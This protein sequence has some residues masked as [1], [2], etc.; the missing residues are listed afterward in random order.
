MTLGACVEI[1]GV[2]RLQAPSPGRCE[3]GGSVM[4]AYDLA[5]LRDCCIWAFSQR[6]SRKGI[7]GLA[8]IVADGFD[9]DPFVEPLTFFA[10]ATALLVGAST[11][12]KTPYY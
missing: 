12:S 3:V 1:Q 2:T 9:L 6:D 8:A 5:G 7:D 4:V 11:P 10:H